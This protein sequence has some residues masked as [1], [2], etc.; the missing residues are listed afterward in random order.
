M[1]SKLS[2]AGCFA[3]SQI[4]RGARS[5]SLMR[6]SRRIVGEI[7]G[8]V[9]T[10]GPAI[11]RHLRILRTAGLL[12]TRHHGTARISELS[13]RPLRAV[14]AI[15]RR[16]GAR[17]SRASSAPSRR[18][19]PRR[20]ERDRYG[21]KGGSGRDH[22]TVRAS[23]EQH[24]RAERSEAAPELNGAPRGSIEATWKFGAAFSIRRSM[25]TGACR[26]EH[27]RTI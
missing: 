8:H 3:P 15:T 2:A 14:C 9:R 11:F 6:G 7:A 20:H 10:S 27:L 16:S 1:G 24:V 26:H 4:R 12:L 18:A 25:S 19:Q 23:A 21:P 22:L 17:A 13:A 5:S